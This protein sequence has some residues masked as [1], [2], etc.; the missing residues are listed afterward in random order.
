[1]LEYVVFFIVA[2]VVTLVVT[3]ALSQWSRTIQEREI[4]RQTQRRK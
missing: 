2:S 3:V 1:M 4:F